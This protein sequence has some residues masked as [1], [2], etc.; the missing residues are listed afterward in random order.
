MGPFVLLDF[1][2]SF[3]DYGLCGEGD[4]QAQAPPGFSAM[5]IFDS[6]GYVAQY[7]LYTIPL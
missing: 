5:C 4:D 2:A 7:I 6:R 1:V 3:I